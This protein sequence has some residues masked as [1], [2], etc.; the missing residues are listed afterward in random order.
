[1]RLRRPRQKAAVRALGG[2]AA[3]LLCGGAIAPR[4]SSPELGERLYREGQL[5]SGEP[6]RGERE[7]ATALLGRDAA[8]AQCHRRSGLGTVEG[9]IVIP[10]ITGHFLFHPGERIAPESQAA[11][12][13][14]MGVPPTPPPRSAYDEAKLAR[15]IRDGLGAGGHPPNNLMPPFQLAG[16][17]NRG[18]AS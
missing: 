14:A 3:L 1:D 10:P 9:R 4:T 16:G 11:R 5:A 7:G 15:A 2:L 6:L 18:L 8:C 12:G 17:S 13:G